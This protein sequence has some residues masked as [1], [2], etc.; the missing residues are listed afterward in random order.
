MTIDDFLK[1]SLK[2]HLGKMKALDNGKLHGAVM[3]QVEKSL[4]RIVLE[5]TDGNQSDASRL[6]GI[7]R[8]TLRKK[9][10]DHKIS[11]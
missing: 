9:I 3:G 2:E 10:R 7:N 11:G 6:L 5:E 8:N 1:K 4:L